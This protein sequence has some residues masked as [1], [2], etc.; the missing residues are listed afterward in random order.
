MPLNQ[1]GV[2][3]RLTQDQVGE[4]VS[5]MRTCVAFATPATLVELV[6]WAEKIFC[7]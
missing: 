1:R 4:G 2:W 5:L 3:T 7:A 6:E